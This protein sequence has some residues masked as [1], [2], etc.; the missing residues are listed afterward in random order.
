MMSQSHWFGNSKGAG[1]SASVYKHSHISNQPDSPKVL[2]RQ[3]KEAPTEDVVEEVAIV[4]VRLKP[5][6]QS[7]APLI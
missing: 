7:W 2:K 4:V 3:K 5:L 1:P 6:L